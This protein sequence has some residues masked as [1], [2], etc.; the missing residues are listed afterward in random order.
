M[1]ADKATAERRVNDLLAIVLDGAQ[2]WDVFQYV[3]E[4]EAEEG[5]VWFVLQGAT[6]LSD[7]MI[8]KYLTR[9]YRLMESAHEKSRRRLFRRHVARLN[10]LYARATTAGELSVA[11]A[12]LRDLAE[13]QRLLPRPE[14]ELRREVER[15]KKLLEGMDRGDGNL[16]GRDRANPPADRGA[17]GAADA[18]TGAIDRGHVPANGGRGT[19]ARPLAGGLAALPFAADVAPLYPP[20][21]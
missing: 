9:A 4:K 20:G 11:R 6:P 8:R 1:K 15:L 7:G 3:R 14:D 19:D 10:H 16:E 13:M 5:S 17:G 18:A 2:G 21:R 12:V